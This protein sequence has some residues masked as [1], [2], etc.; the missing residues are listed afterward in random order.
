M[1]QKFNEINKKYEIMPCPKP[2]GQGCNY[3]QWTRLIQNLDAIQQAIVECSKVK[4][5]EKR[6]DLG[7]K[8]EGVISGGKYNVFQVL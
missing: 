7:G 8:L 1:E 4:N 2:V 6:F 3:K 5:Y